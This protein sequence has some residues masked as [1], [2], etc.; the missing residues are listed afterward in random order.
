M[1]AAGWFR[2]QHEEME[3]PEKKIDEQVLTIRSIPISIP[4]Q[5]RMEVQGEAIMHLSD[6]E[7]YNKTA[8]VPL[9]NA[10]N[11]CAGA[12]RNLDTAVTASRRLDAYFY[13]VGILK[14]EV[15]KIMFR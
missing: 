1:K 14:E 13:N 10:R 8:K 12:L 11:A 5:G 4:F 15:L 3:L 2:P 7:A 9:K 6:L